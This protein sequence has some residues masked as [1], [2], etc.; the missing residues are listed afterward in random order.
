MPVYDIEGVAVDFP[1]EAYPCQVRARGMRVFTTVTV[2]HSPRCPTDRLHAQ[3]DLGAGPGRARNPRCA[4]PSSC[5]LIQGHTAPGCGA[6]VAVDAARRAAVTCAVLCALSCCRI[7]FED[8]DARPR[9]QEENGLLESP[10]GTGKTLCLLCA[11]LAWREAWS[12]R[13]RGIAAA[14]QLLAS[15]GCRGHG[16]QSRQHLKRHARTLVVSKTRCTAPC[17]R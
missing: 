16:H 8:P 10:T 1:H 7:P 12:R 6:Q 4:G 14:T 5:C 15:P 3:G 11:T 13:V 17:C 2:A 9:A